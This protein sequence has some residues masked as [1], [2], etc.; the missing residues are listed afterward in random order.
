MKIRKHLLCLA[1]MLVL[2]FTILPKVSIKAEEAKD[3]ITYEG[4]FSSESEVITYNID[5]DFTSMDSA[6]ICLVKTGKTNM[7][8][9]IKDA[10]GNQVGVA[11]TLDTLARRWIFI[12]KPSDDTTVVTYTVSLQATEYDEADSSFRLMAGN[13]DDTEEMISGSE[14]MV[15]LDTYTEEKANQVL[16]YYTPDNY[17]SWYRFT[18]PKYDETVITILTYDKNIRF[19]LYEVDN[20]RG[21]SFYD[22]NVNSK[23]HRTKYCLSYGHAEKQRFDEL[24]SGKEYCLVIYSSKPSGVHAFAGKTMNLTV[25]KPNMCGNYATYY[26]SEKITGTK[27]AYSS[28]TTIYANSLPSTAVVDSVTLTSP[29]GVKMSKIGI[30]RTKSPTDSVWNASNLQTI[31]YGYVKDSLKNKSAVGKWLVSFKTPSTVASYS[32]LPGIKIIYYYELGD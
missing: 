21:D 3:Y 5:L 12:D 26:A 24:V 30:W 8:M 10:E 32:M 14:N 4:E 19:R 7:K 13:K 1:F 11:V 20:I 16:T 31:N 18:A 17:E 15:Y 9:I 25:G 28:S 27:L 22:S 6:S 23:A 29:F 2:I